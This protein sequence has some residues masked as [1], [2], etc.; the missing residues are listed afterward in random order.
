MSAIE[1]VEGAA[2]ES[3]A[4]KRNEDSMH[5]QDDALLSSPDKQDEQL[6]NINASSQVDHIGGGD[7]GPFI[8]GASENVESTKE[9]VF[10]G[11]K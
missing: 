8:T 9:G 11:I 6:K 4:K 3:N 7:R 1:K 10:M 2:S 5:V